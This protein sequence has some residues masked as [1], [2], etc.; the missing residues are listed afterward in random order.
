MAS[1]WIVNPFDNL[2][3]EGAKPQRYSLLASE[4]TGRGHGVVW[5][6]ASFSHS[7][8]GRRMGADGKPL[9]AAWERGDGVRMRLVDVPPYSGN[10][11]LAR[12]R[13]HGEFA[14]NL[15]AQAAAEVAAGALE[16]PDMVVASTP[17]LSVARA[18]ADFKARW[19]CRVALDVMDA[20]PDAFSVLVPGPAV[21]GRLALWTVLSPLVRLSRRGFRLAD[22]VT[23][24]SRA[25]LEL[26]RRRG[27]SARMGWFPHSCAAVASGPFAAGAPGSPLRLCYVGNLGRFY[28]LKTMVD[29]VR[30]ARGNGVDATLEI[31]GSGPREGE[32]RRMVSQADGVAFRGFLDA[33]GLDGLLSRCEVGIIP[34]LPKSAVAMP[35]KLPDYA[36]HGLAVLECLGGESGRLVGRHRAGLHY[37]AGDARSLADA[38]AALDADRA[39]LAAMRAASAEMARAEFL[40]SNIYPMFADLL[41]N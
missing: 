25:Y 21:L 15:A 18:L 31:A 27:A 12:M 37:G 36:S 34:L 20:W 8:K 33:A 1:V 3:E 39:G 10:V 35:Y 6:T 41:L 23:S 11:G 22:V 2:P 4:I 16:P 5:W 7:R 17:P 38:I 32:V 19:R 26:A 40:E 28:D 13:S 14:G 29:A 30:L 24:T 9:P